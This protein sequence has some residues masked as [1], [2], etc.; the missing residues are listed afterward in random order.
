M[1]LPLKGRVAVVTGASRGV[2]RGIALGLGEAGAVVYLTGRTTAPGAG[3]WPGSIGETAAEVTRL[4]G[5]GVAVRCDHRRDDEVEALFRQVEAER[6]RLDLLVNSATA[7][8]PG[9]VPL[10]IPFWE[11]PLEVWDLVHA[12]GL[13]SHYVASVSAAR[14]ML[15][16]G[17]GLI[18]NISSSGAVEYLFNVPYG[19]GKAGVDKL[20]ADTAHELQQH[21]VAVVSVWPEFT[22]TEEVT[23]QYTRYGLIPED[24]REACS[25][26]FNGR[27][28]AA[29]A[30]DAAIMEKTGRVL[31][32][33]DLAAEYGV[34]DPEA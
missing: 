32:V 33:A 34:V 20:T 10:D 26:I 22:R 6:G 29:L 15:A 28:V 19:V 31:R 21:G 25:P 7:F 11:L 8:P 24:L 17:Q 12:V 27:V 13:R 2:G 30:A 9:G 14:L 5:E 16:Q 4:G 23:A 3:P 18:V 1:G